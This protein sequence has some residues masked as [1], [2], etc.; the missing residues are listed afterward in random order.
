MLLLLAVIDTFLLVVII[1]QRGIKLSALRRIENKMS[2]LSDAVAAITNDVTELQTAGQRVI[3]LLSQPNPDVAAAV[4]ALKTA[5]AGFDA[6]RDSLNSAGTT[7][8]A[9]PGSAEPTP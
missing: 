1:C 7:A 4:D 9:A 3:D 2:E 6:L 5:D 8:G